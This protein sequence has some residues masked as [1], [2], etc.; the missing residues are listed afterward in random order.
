V[1]HRPHWHV[2]ERRPLYY[3][4]LWLDRRHWLDEPW[5]HVGLILVLLLTIWLGWL[6]VTLITGGNS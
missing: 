1:K 3:Q 6:L 5:V 2:F 4:S